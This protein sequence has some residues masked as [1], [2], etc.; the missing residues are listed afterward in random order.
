MSLQCRS[1]LPLNII[2]NETVTRGNGWPWT[3]SILWFWTPK[4]S[5]LKYDLNGIK[6]Q[7]AGK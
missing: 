4:G 6:E 5:Q 3:P 2:S 7:L 1:R